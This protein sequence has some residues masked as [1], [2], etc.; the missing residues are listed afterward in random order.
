MAS[1]SLSI[2]FTGSGGAGVMTAGQMLLAAA[3]RAG[4]YGL[5]TRSMGPQIRG[6]ESAAFLRLARHPVGAPD[7]RIDLLVAI[8][9]ENVTR[10]LAEL[11]MDAGG[12]IL[13]DPAQ[14]AVPEGL[15]AHGPTVGDL[16]LKETAKSIDGGRANMVALGAAAGIAGID[17]A[18][19][20]A[21]V[22]R[23]LG[24]KGEAALTAARAAIEAGFAQARE[25][26]NG[27]ALAPP[28]TAPAEGTRWNVSGNEAT[29]LGALAGGVRFV[30][31]YPITPAT[32]V[33]EYLAPRLEKL[34]GNLVQAEDELA[35]INMVLG[36]GY[37]GVPALTATAGPGFALMTEGIGLGIATE[38]PAVVVDVMRGGPSTGI[39]TK[40]EQAD[41][42]IALSGMHG[43]A[44]H[45]V[46]APNAIAD[47]R[48]TTEWAV[49]LAEALQVP[50]VVLS[51]QFMG[52]ARAVLDAPGAAPDVPARRTAAPDDAGTYRRFAVTGDFVSPMALPGTPNG[53]Y[54]ADGLEHDA[55]GAP[56]TLPEVHAEQLHKRRRKLEVFDYGA[57]WAD[58]EGDGPAAIITWGSVTG[59]VREAA[60]RLRADGHAV[61]VISLRLLLPAQ[62][63]RLAAALEGVDR[64]LVVEQTEGAQF[65]RYLRAW[66][67]LPADVRCLN[68]PGPLALRPGEI[69]DALKEGAAP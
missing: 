7:D 6:G 58:V 37:G 31:A 39:P 14:G 52:Q 12:L 60:D 20:D 5:M 11:P 10:F 38:T 59:A 67:D 36:A 49:R 25:H 63:E 55:S 42:D 13:A 23:A 48:A 1:A 56:S 18:A 34:G 46:V 2:A 17:R 15:V 27:H 8:D 47:C 29:G 19:V 68:R 65:H 69:A 64:V 43:D 44:P 32:D 22:N 33:L 9:W 35:S 54:T 16:P 53:M 51:D 62:P 24:R 61:R 3:G 28:E 45:V 30:A 41:L 26:E 50:T 40:S 57:F 21:V 4:H 66:Y